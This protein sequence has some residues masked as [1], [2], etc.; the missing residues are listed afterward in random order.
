MAKKKEVYKIGDEVLYRSF[1]T[2][3]FHKNSKVIL[4]VLPSK[5]I[6]TYYLVASN[7]SGFTLDGSERGGVWS[8]KLYDINWDVLKIGKKYELADESQLMHC[9]SI[10]A[11]EQQIKKEIYGS[12]N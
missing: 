3:E 11:V 1:G 6:P 9:D 2:Q 7:K 10:D 4:G 5:S 12:S 8:D